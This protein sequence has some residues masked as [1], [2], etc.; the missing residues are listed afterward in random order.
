MSD[1]PTMPP[2]FSE[3][4]LF[5]HAAVRVAAVAAVVGP[6]TTASAVARPVAVTAA[7]KRL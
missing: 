1:R 3:I 5:C 2:T 4:A 6:A 7:Q